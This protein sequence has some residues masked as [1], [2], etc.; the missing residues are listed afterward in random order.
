VRLT[1][2]RHGDASQEASRDEERALTKRGRADSRRVGRALERRGVRF[3]AVITSPLV[4]AVQTAEIVVGAMDRRRV[5][6]TVSN[7]L[8]PEGQ[9]Q[10]VIKLLEGLAEAD[11]K[12]VALVAHEPLLSRVAALVL[13]VSRFP[14]LRKGEAL[15]IKLAD[16]PSRPGSAR[17]RL[18]PET[19]RRRRVHLSSK[20]T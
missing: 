9:P 16:G 11:G 8:V 6:V 5:R 20:A 10:N 7:V 15:R 12:S 18:D 3:S 13:G 14:P 2:I 4:R 17:W 1:L 19:G